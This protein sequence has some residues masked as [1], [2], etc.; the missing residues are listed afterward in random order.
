MIFLAPDKIPCKHCGRQEKRHRSRHDF[1]RRE[2]DVVRVGYTVALSLC[3]GYV[4]KPDER[5][6]CD[7]GY[8]GLEHRE[9]HPPP[10]PGSLMNFLA[11]LTPPS[12]HDPEPRGR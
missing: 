8:G 10:Q 11:K 7:S 6:N 2:D 12:Q 4:P 1:R 5:R 9:L 3:E